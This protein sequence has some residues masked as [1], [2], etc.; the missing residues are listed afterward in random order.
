MGS[1]DYLNSA[2]RAA[3]A[4]SVLAFVALGAAGYN[5]AVSAW[6]GSLVA[7][8]PAAKLPIPSQRRAL[9]A[10]FAKSAPDCAS[11]E[12]ALVGAGSAH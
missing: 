9:P 4:F 5:L 6:G 2:R 12:V 7:S 3:I 10:C 8:A 11:V 1:S